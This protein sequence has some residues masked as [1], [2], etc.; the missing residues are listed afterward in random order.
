MSLPLSFSSA[1]GRWRCG[2]QGAL[3]RGAQELGSR[4]GRAGPS[5]AVARGR[6]RRAGPI[7]CRFPRAAAC[8]RGVGTEQQ[9]PSRPS[10]ALPL[11]PVA[12]LL[13]PRSVY[14]ED[15]GFEFLTAVMSFVA[16]KKK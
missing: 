12:T 16:S 6:L 9:P 14:R 13:G 3:G 5:G 11:R 4:G 10:R 1:R 2:P 8:G 15:C 7:P